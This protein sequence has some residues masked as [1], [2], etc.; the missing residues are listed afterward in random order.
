MVGSEDNAHPQALVNAPVDDV[1]A[2]VV[3]VIRELK[4]Q[5]IIT[6]DPIGGYHHPDHIAI[7]KATLKAFQAAGDGQGSS[8]E[9]G[10]AF[11]L[12]S[13]TTTCFPRGVMKLT[14][15]LMPL[16]G[17][18]PRHLG[19]NRD[20]DLASVANVKFPMHASVRCPGRTGQQGMRPRVLC[21]PDREPPQ[22][23]GLFGFLQRLSRDDRDFFMRAYPP[24]KGGCVKEIS[25]KELSESSEY[26]RNREGIMT[27]LETSPVRRA[28]EADVVGEIAVETGAEGFIEL[29]NVN[30]VEYIFMNPGTDT[31]PIQETIARF[32][33][34]GRR[35]PQVI[36]CPHE[37]VAM[38]AA[39]GYFAVTGRPQVVLVHVDVGTQNIG[40]ALHNAQRSRIGV[41]VCAG[42]SPSIF[43]GE[44]PGGRSMGIMWWQE[45]RDQAGI[46]RNFTKWDYELRFNENVHH[47][48]Q[49]AFQVR[50]RSR[51]GRCTSPCPGRC[52]S[53]RSRR[54]RSSRSTGSPLR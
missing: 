1:A 42:R 8:P 12:R 15:T 13:S 2:R 33:A 25:S 50:L 44:R 3:K 9:A 18:D 23:R 20:I 19:K 22:R 41:V 17:Q 10:P 52:W 45:Q 4:P 51:A 40:G 49:R 35:T 39:H 37:T 47:V 38:A 48:V 26:I 5:V 34:T 27:S 6:S 29:L 54:C 11:S 36:L 16:F 14:V 24:A 32:K 53:R 31:T 30:R 28:K 21:Q 7:H 43:E 46:V